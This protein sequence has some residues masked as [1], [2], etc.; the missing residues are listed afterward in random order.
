MSRLGIITRRTLL[1]GVAAVAGGVAFG[2]WQSRKP[3]AN[4]LEGMLA[5]GE[6][7]LNPW[8]KI[9]SDNTITVY[10]PRA[11]MGQGISTSLP[12]LVAEELNVPLAIIKV[13][14]GPNS[15]AY[16]N[17]GIDRKSVV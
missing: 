14:H 17:S 9:G 8:L 7:S 2:Y 4:P 1:V 12:A 3:W 6:V 5:E 16:F 13:E 15:G 11:E 10:A